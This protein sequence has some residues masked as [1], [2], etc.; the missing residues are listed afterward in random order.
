MHDADHEVDML[1]VGAGGAGLTAAVVG[2][3]EGLRVLLCEKS[4]QVGGTTAMSGG[5]VWVPGTELSVRDGVP[6]TIA[7]GRTYLEGEIGAFLRPDMIDAFLHS[8]NEAISYLEKRTDVKFR[9]A[10]RHPDYHPNRAGGTV[11]GRAL[12]PVP[13]DGRLLGRD[14]DLVRPPM[15]EFLALGGMMVGRE[16]IPHLVRPFGSAASFRL[17]LKLL[18]RHLADRM[19]YR[20][21]TRLLMGNAL[22]AR[23]LLSARTRG[24]D[25]RTDTALTELLTSGGR[26]TGAVLTSGAT[27]TRVRAT[28]GIVLATGGFAASTRWRD[29][30]M[31]GLGVDHWV[32]FS[33]A[34]G[35]ALDAAT[36]IGAAIDRRHGSPGFWMPASA[37]KASGGREVVF[38]H[39]RDRAKP[40]LIAVNADGRRFVNEANSYQDFVTAMFETNRATRAIPAWLVCDRRF[41]RAYGFGLIR[42]VW[43]RLSPYIASGYLTCAGS[44][45]DLA[46]RIGVDPL[47][48]AASVREHNR[49]AETG[50]DEAFGKG[51]TALNRHNGDPANKPNPCLHPIATPPYFAVPVYPAALGTSTGLATDADAQVLDENGAPLP[52]LY[53]CGN[54]MSS[55]MQ[56]FYPGPGITLGPALVFAY[57]AVRHLALRAA[58]NKESR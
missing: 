26:V 41:V 5:T 17:T 24:V 42:P 53:A 46:Q 34:T 3:E 56:G 27:R 33:G 14:F 15:P 36:A 19:R 4:S 44:I 7:A 21:G 2:A 58:D 9:A 20:R 43:Q 52:G 11:G 29:D 39:I 37:M 31:A 6:D 25:I 28:R 55:I 50:V 35:D 10:T 54:D 13:F 57:R 51:S 40:G 48:L 30:L 47:G 8:G 12:L 49:F 18:A 23:L 16:E 45:E 1:V 22:I 38:P 32:T